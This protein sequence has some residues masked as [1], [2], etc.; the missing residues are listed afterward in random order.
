MYYNPIEL[1][2]WKM[3][4]AEAERKAMLKYQTRH[5]KFP[6]AQML[7]RLLRGVLLLFNVRLLRSFRLLHYSVQQE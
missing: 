6:E 2:V 3:R 5:L 1:E 7:E 4:V